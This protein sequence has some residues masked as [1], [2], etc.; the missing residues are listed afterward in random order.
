ME[1]GVVLHLWKNDIYTFGGEQKEERKNRFKMIGKDVY[2]FFQDKAIDAGFEDRE[3]QWEMSCEIV[4]GI[5]E[6]KHVLVEAGVGI[7]KSF[8]YIVPIL[9]YNKIYRRPVVIATSTIALQEQLIHDIEKIMDM[10]NYEVE[11][12]IAKGQNH[13]LCKKRFDDCF[14]PKFIK[15]SKLHQIINDAI[16]KFGYEKAD[17]R[18]PI[19]D[20]IWNRINVKEY[21][22][23]LCKDKCSYKGYCHYHNLRQ[24]MIYTHGI[25]VCNQDLLTANMNKKANYRKQFMNENIGIIVIDETHNL[26]N[27]VRS[28]VTSCIS[29]KQ[30][31]DSMYGAGKAVD[32]FDSAFTKELEK[33]DHLI[34]AVFKSLLRQMDEQDEEAEKN[35][36][37]I[38]RYYVGKIG[39][40][41]VKLRDILNEIH[42][43]ASM[44]FGDFLG[45]RSRKNYDEEIEQL[46][47]NVAFLKS[48]M[49]RANS[50]DIFWLERDKGNHGINGVRLYKCPKEVNKITRQIMFSDPELPVILTSATITSGKN[51]DYIK[52]YAYFINNTGLQIA[53]VLICEP[54]ISPFN[55]DEHA[56]I[57]YTEHMPHPTKE[58]ATFIEEGVKEIIKLLQIS[59]GKSLILFTAK[60]DMQ[61]VYDKLQKENLLFEII[62]QKGN[63][64]QAETL[65]KFR[66]NTNSVLLGT[67][68]YWEGI[69]IEGVSLSHVI[70]FK[71]PFPVRE[72]IIDFKYEQSNGNGL[73]EVSVP[74]M[75]IKLKQGIGRL[76]RSEN[77]RGIV[78]II[79]SRVGSKSKALYK[80]IVWESLPI[81]KKTN[82][83]EEIT[84]FYNEVVEQ[85]KEENRNG[86]R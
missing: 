55:Y 31:K 22:P 76:I 19:P 49:K 57:Y 74:E 73:M 24:K 5:K 3:G 50:E 66:I 71:L 16:C 11:V 75:V 32:S 15:E 86:S 45:D 17:W 12:L 33:A 18:V 20:E 23:H 60:T 30:L 43:K 83:I 67:G 9:Y 62:M 27:K 6:N 25:I 46:E 53:Q 63:S 56:M 69:N 41:F 36:Q 44:S 21:N 13:F 14:T 28:S 47:E 35:G 39:L 40:N 2:S 1:E 37:D 65:E 34:D 51:E 48:I 78:S 8:A 81:K 4:D 84:T 38:D 72:P 85:K 80:E 7:G 82:N 61:A 52:N 70:I 42:F 79:D 10:L 26:E 68:S 58:R 59:N 29:L 77:D 64:K 54:K